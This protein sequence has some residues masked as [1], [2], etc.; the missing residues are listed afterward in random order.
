[1]KRVAGVLIIILV[2][3][4]LST[5]CTMPEKNDEKTVKDIF[6][7][8]TYMTL[9]AYGDGAPKAVDIAARKIEELDAML[10]TG[11]NTSDISILNSSGKAVLPLEA[12]DIIRTAIQINEDTDGAFNPLIYPVMK[13]WGFDTGK[14]RV[15]LQSELDECMLHMDT[16]MINIDET[17]G[18]VKF[19]DHKMQLDLGGI[20]KG[21]TSNRIIQIYKD[22]GV[23]SGIVSLG[24]NVQTIGTKPDG[25]PWKV[26]IRSPD[27]SSEYSG[28]L[29]VNDAAV[30]TSGGYE[31][32]FEQNGNT[33]HHIID[34]ATGK[35]ARSGLRSVTIVNDEGMLADALSTAV[36][37]MGHKKAVKFWKEYKQPFEMI[38]ITD[39]GSQYVTEGLVS[40]YQCDTDYE[41]I[42][43]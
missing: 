1:M 43:K 38:L 40:L 24:G 9:T 20:A 15:P 21:Y 25:S 35:P 30:V 18:E 26:A 37:I 27:G 39:D 31:R 28:V 2:L 22:N 23:E 6:A 8:D 4:V 17:V 41:V 33:Y 34:P 36:Y 16:G 5:S 32:Y 3:L 10:S 11:I 29:S 13:C 14:Y 7:M 42:K 19:A 12:I